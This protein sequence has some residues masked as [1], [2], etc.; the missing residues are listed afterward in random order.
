MKF[1]YN[2]TDERVFPSLSIVVKPGDSFEAPDDFSAANVSAEKATP[3]A[4]P[5]PVTDP[6]PTVGE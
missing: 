2:G 3:V 1:T 5:A 6:T 4:D